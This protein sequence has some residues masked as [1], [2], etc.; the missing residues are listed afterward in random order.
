MVLLPRTYFP[1]PHPVGDGD[2][3]DRRLGLVRYHPEGFLYHYA[4]MSFV[5]VTP[6]AGTPGCGSPSICLRLSCLASATAPIS[7][8]TAAPEL[9][10]APPR[11]PGTLVAAGG[12]PGPAPLLVGVGRLDDPGGER[13]GADGTVLAAGQRVGHPG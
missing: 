1:A 4:G 8:A 5:G 6:T 13:G 3:Y 9:T 11:K 12:R 7:F 10:P 2:Y